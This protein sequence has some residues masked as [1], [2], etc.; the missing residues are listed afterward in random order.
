MKVLG[1]PSQYGLEHH[2]LVDL[3]TVYW[4]FPPPALIEQVILREEGQAVK[5]G[6]VVAQTGKHTGRSAKDKYVVLYGG[7]EEDKFWCQELNQPISP[8]VFERLQKKV[9]SYLLGRDVFVQDMVVGAHPSHQRPYESLQSWHGTAYSRGI[10]SGDL[11]RIRS[12]R[13]FQNT[14]LYAALAALP[15]QL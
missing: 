10:F 11:S 15:I 4:N 12:K 5:N 1:T 8:A 14:R 9:A 13:T 3:R 6:A 7:S 2:G